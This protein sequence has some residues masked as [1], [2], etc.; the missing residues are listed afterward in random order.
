MGRVKPKLDED[1]DGDAELEPLHHIGRRLSRQRVDDVASQDHALASASG[2]KLGFLPR[3]EGT[4]KRT[5]AELEAL[6]WGT[7]EPTPLHTTV[8]AI[9]LDG[10]AKRQPQGSHHPKTR[11]HARQAAPNTHSPGMWAPEWPSPHPQV[12]P[13]APGSKPSR[14]LW[15]RPGTLLL[16]LSAA[17]KASLLP[18]KALLH[19][20]CSLLSSSA[21]HQHKAQHPQHGFHKGR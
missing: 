12:S 5:K 18:A 15:V 2:H 7:G 4:C 16:T 9:R 10:D 1:G 6:G 19:P 20:S 3:A 14:N 8:P 11:R 21:F 13:R 17:I